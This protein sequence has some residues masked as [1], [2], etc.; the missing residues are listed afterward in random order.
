[1]S[2]NVAR[3]KRGTRQSKVEGD[4]EAYLDGAITMAFATAGLYFLRFWRDTRDRLFAI[5]ACSFWLLG[6]VRIGLMLAGEADEADRRVYFYL[7]R[8][9]AYLLILYAI[10][11]KNGWFV[12]SKKRRPN[13]SPR[14]PD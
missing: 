2:N 8:L 7:L 4:M 5:F 6:I 13:E 10:C 9:V 11:E 12:A 1:M 14:V 3:A